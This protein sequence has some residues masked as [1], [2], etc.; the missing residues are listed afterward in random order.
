MTPTSE[1]YDISPFWQLPSPELDQLWEDLHSFGVSRIPKSEVVLLPHKTSPIPGDEEDYV[2]ELDVFHEL[3]CLNMIRQSIYSDY[4][5]HMWPNNTDTAWHIGHCLD[6]IRQSLMCSAD[7][8]VMVWQW[9][10]ALQET[11]E[12]GNVTHICRRFDKI[13]E[14]AKERQILFNKTV[15]VEDDIIIPVYHSD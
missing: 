2:I 11:V 10:D 5:P 3:H 8:S 15:R 4:Y 7:I 9:S 14:W 6:S 13:Q 1:A 12:H